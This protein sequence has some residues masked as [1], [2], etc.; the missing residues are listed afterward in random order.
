MEGRHSGQNDESRRPRRVG[1]RMKTLVI[2][3]AFPPMRTGEADH[4]FRLCQD[5]AIVEWTSTC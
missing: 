5:L 2:S 1:A 4:T 3:A